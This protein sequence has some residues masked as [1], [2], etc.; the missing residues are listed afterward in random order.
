[1][2]YRRSIERDAS[3]AAV[4]V[5]L[6]LAYYE[7][8][9]AMEAFTVVREGLADRSW[10]FEGKRAAGRR[11][12]S[13]I[14]GVRRKHSRLPSGHGDTR[15]GGHRAVDSVAVYLGTQAVERGPSRL[16]LMT[17]SS[18][19]IPRRA[20]PDERQQRQRC[21][22]KYRQSLVWT[23]VGLQG[24]G[25]DKGKP[26]CGTTEP[27]VYLPGHPE[28]LKREGHAPWRQQGKWVRPLDC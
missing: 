26:S 4:F 13:Q 17:V 9:Q 21:G 24:A 5:D 15:T 8:H 22:R 18:Y 6:A 27:L 23:R 19:A 10:E 11:T 1:M 2:Y 14:W 20:D 25:Q 28:V 3:Q 16:Y 12:Y 7:Q